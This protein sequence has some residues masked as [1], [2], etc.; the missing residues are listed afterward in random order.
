MNQQQFISEGLQQELA[1][2]I[3]AAH[4][5]IAAVRQEVEKQLKNLGAQQATQPAHSPKAQETNGEIALLRGQLLHLDALAERQKRAKPTLG[6]QNH[7][8]P[9]DRGQA[10]FAQK[11]RAAQPS[12]ALLFWSCLAAVV[13]TL[14]IG[15]TWG[16]WMTAGAAQALADTSAKAAVTQ[17]LAPICV[18]QFN[19]DPARDA[20]LTELQGVSSYQRAVFVK[21]QMWATM[22]GETEPNSQVATECAKLLMQIGQ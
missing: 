21:D 19:L 4:G 8:G 11:W 12:K 2:R 7:S 6:Q 1:Q 15:F 5:N 16:G 18:A 9:R 17:S 14:L 22:P 3:Q 10:T 20:K 13:L